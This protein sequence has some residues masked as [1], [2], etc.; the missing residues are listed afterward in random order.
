[1]EGL[2]GFPIKLQFSDFQ[3]VSE[4]P[5]FQFRP[6]FQARPVWSYDAERGAFDNGAFAQSTFYMQG[7][8]Y[9]VAAVRVANRGT[10]WAD[11]QIAELQVWGKNADGNYAVICIPILEG[12]PNTEGFNLEKMFKADG[13]VDLIKVFP[14]GDDVNMYSYVSCN[15]Y[16][17]VDKAYKPVSYGSTNVHV[18]FF[19]RWISVTDNVYKNFVDNKSRPCGIPIELVP[20][21]YVYSEYMET[22]IGRSV[23]ITKVFDTTAELKKRTIFKKVGFQALDEKKQE[24]TAKVFDL[25]VNS[26]VNDTYVFDS[27]KAEDLSTYLEKKKQEKE[28]Q[29]EKEMAVPT[30][31]VFTLGGMASTIG[32]ILGV[33]A[34][35]IV[36]GFIWKWYRKPF[37]VMSGSALA[38]GLESAPGSALA[39]GS[40][41]APISGLKSASA[42][43]TVVENA[44]ENAIET[45]TPL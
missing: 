12:S 19:A 8:T 40:T 16:V 29:K 1:V 3:N 14:Q 6:L 7:K 23:K 37:V 34:L 38:P 5:S 35:I 28:K 25:N 41:L 21:E 13:A 44:I 2:R 18:L 33:L 36:A 24:G 9:A 20:N 15:P 43:E 30:E 17:A 45:A 31:P 42:L 4:E 32:I 22:D 27:S 26:M 39:P 11:V 10:H